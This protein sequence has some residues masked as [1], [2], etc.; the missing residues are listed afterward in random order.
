[1]TLKPSASMKRALTKVKKTVKVSVA[2]TLTPAGAPA[3]K[4]TVSVTLAR[5]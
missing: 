2:M 5:K 3:L 4:A 1:M